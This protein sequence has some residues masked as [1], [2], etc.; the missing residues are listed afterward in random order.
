MKKFIVLLLTIIISV[1]GF[2]QR[3]V[4]FKLFKTREEVSKYLENLASESNCSLCKIH[5]DIDGDGN[6]IISMEFPVNELVV[7]AV[8]VM[9]KFT[10]NKV[11]NQDLCYKMVVAASNSHLNYY[12]D[13]IHKNCNR[14]SDGIWE[15]NMG[16]EGGTSTFYINYKFLQLKTENSFTIEATLVLK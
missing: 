9:A 8:L 12:L 13:D 3:M 7:R 5:N 10:Y 6:L 14:N 15:R 4:E 16:K 2:G 11:I 1:N